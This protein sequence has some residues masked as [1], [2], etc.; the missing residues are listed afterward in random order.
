MRTLVA[1]EIFSTE[2]SYCK[3]LD[4]IVNEFHT[5][6]CKQE[7]LISKQTLQ[8]IFSNI[9]D[10]RIINRELLEALERKMDQWTSQQE[11]GT[12]FQKLVPF[13]KLYRDY[14]E[15]YDTAINRYQ[16]KMKDKPFAQ[17]IQGIEQKVGGGLNLPA[18]LIMPIQRIPRY[19]LLCSELL[20][21]TPKDHTDYAPIQ[22]A[23]GKIEAVANYIN[24]SIRDRQNIEKL[25]ELQR[26]FSGN[27][28]NLVKQ[29][30]V[31]KKEGSLM[32]VCR[33]S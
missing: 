22:S 27:L 17:V 28:P 16:E 21:Y 14:C 13:L 19:R 12:V 9:E 24:D 10:I 29:G 31:L 23:L 2:Q 4:L 8:C 5:P 33:V 25:K 1:K 6:L 11:L 32:K 18:L 15:N 20:K 7:Q 26:K 30:R 3:S